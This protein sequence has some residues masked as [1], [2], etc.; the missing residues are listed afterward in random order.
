VLLDKFTNSKTSLKDTKGTNNTDLVEADRITKEG[1]TLP[2]STE[3]R[4]KA[5]RTIE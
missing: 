5:S 1:D 4:R 2:I 3:A